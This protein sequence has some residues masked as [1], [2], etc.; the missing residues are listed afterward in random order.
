MKRHNRIHTVYVSGGIAGLSPDDVEDYFRT[1]EE[2]LRELGLEV[3]SPI[4]GK[5]MDTEVG[6]HYEVNEIVHRDENDVKHSDLM[7]AYPSDKSIGT[8][9]ELYLA[10]KIC[11]IPVIV[12]ATSPHITGHYWIRSYASKIVPTLEDAIDYVSAWYL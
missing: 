7:I 4:R 6:S 3:L 12:I 11:D 10:R 9:M 1:A 8:I 2:K 5:V